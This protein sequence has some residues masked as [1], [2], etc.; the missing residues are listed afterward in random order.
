MRLLLAV[1]LLAMLVCV[2]RA[3]A[4]ETKAPGCDAMVGVWQ[5]VEP[6]AP[7]HAIIAKQGTKYLGIFVNTLPEPYTGQTTTRTNSQNPQAGSYAV[8]G[9]WEYTCEAA[10]DK[11]RLTLRWL[12]SSYQPQDVGSEAILEVELT[13][14]QA[15]WWFI[16]ADG[17]RGT[18][19]AG[20]LLR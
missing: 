11:L 10:S 2:G 4:G 18:M 5:Y 15:K 20:R 13:G 7:G 6:S 16:G 14:S 8:A 19:G 17:K 3:H 1:G 9:A 12:Y